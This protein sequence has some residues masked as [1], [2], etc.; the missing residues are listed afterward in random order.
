MSVKSIF[1]YSFLLVAVL[2]LDIKFGSFFD[3]RA[4]EIRYKKE[5]LG[6]SLPLELEEKVLLE[7][8]RLAASSAVVLVSGSYDSVLRK[9]RTFVDKRYKIA[10]ER[11]INQ[12][13]DSRGMAKDSTELIWGAW[14]VFGEGFAKMHA[15]GMSFD[16]P[17]E[18]ELTTESYNSLEKLNA[19][20][21]L[22]IRIADGKPLFQKDCVLIVLRRIDNSK[23]WAFIWEGRIPLPFKMNFNYNL[24]TDTEIRMIDEFVA[25]LIDAKAKYFVP[26]PVYRDKEYWNEFITEIKKATNDL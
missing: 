3:P 2:N 6:D 13:V 14:P 10:V 8:G 25:S 22:E 16:R 26:S 1:F 19:Y 24:V 4:D 11:E 20:S 21:R 15:L 5:I 7:S 9:L 17:R 12:R 23:E 18:Y